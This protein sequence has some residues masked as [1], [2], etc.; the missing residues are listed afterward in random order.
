MSDGPH[1]SLPLRQHWQDLAERS[2]KRAFPP[3]QVCEALPYAIKR[4][5]LDAPIAKLREIMNG[6]TLF[7]E[8]RVEQ[9]EGV[10]ASCRGSAAANKVIDCLVEA[11]IK[12]AT[13]DAAMQLAL[14]NAA[15]DTARDSLRGI[16]EHYQRKASAR[17]AGYVRDRLDSARKSL[18]CEALAAELLSPVH[19]HK[20]SIKLARRTGLDDG[21]P[22]Q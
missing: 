14:R 2:A 8:L 5:I 15:D 3:D 12:G 21:P 13:G 11:A 1:R 10:R 19:P 22:K 9:L 17:E 18:D 4:D 20:R 7:P 16:E 6:G